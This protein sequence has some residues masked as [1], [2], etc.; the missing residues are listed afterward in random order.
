MVCGAGWTGL[1]GVRVENAAPVMT[2]AAAGI[3][4]HAGGEPIPK[5]WYAPSMKIAANTPLDLVISCMR[6]ASICT[7]LEYQN[8]YPNP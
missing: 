8:A 4:I 3:W 6:L 7:R 1:K 5:R 2:S